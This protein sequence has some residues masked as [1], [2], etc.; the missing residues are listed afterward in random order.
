[1]TGF[2]GL[3]FGLSQRPANGVP[4]PFQAIALPC[5]PPLGVGLAPVLDPRGVAEVDACEDVASELAA[6]WSRD[7]QSELRAFPEPTVCAA[8]VR[9]HDRFSES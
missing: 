4:W 3:F 7:I 2:F 9:S 8:R 5:S 6:I 1:V